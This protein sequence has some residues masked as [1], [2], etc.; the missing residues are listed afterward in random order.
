MLNE[1]F[2]A[3]HLC[4]TPIQQISSRIWI[5]NTIFIPKEIL[6]KTWLQWL[7]NN[8]VH[9]AKKQEHGTPKMEKIKRKIK[10][11]DCVHGD[12]QNWQLKDNSKCK[13]NCI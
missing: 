11:T 1:M 2:P 3:S 5:R 10:E 6:F 4:Y 8:S 7:S 13:S 12:K 9:I